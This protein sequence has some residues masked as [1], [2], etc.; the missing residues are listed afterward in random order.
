M[1]R[2]GGPILI[3]ES[4]RLR[5]EIP[6]V[7]YRIDGLRELRLHCQRLQRRVGVRAFE[8]TSINGTLEHVNIL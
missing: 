8:E 5:R 7:G 2:H 3:S 6:P 4:D 1:D